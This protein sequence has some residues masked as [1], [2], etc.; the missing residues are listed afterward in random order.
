M[1]KLTDNKVL[2]SLVAINLFGHMAISGG[3]IT[4]SLYA[5][6][7][8]SNVSSVGLLIALYGILPMFFSLPIGRWVDRVG[9]FTPML[10]GITAVVCGLIVP[11]IF[12]EPVV[13]ILTAIL[14]GTGFMMVALSAQHSIGHLFNHEVTRRITAFGWLALGH[15]SSGVLGPMLV[16][17]LIDWTSFKVAFIFLIVCACI[18]LW[19]IKLNENPLKAIVIEKSPLK[20]HN[21]WSLVGTNQLKRVYVVGILVAIPWD[22]FVFLMPIL[23]HQQNL[24]ASAIG[25]ILS[26]LAMGTFSIRFITARWGHRFSEW[27]MLRSAVMVIVFVYLALPFVKLPFLFFLLSFTLGM[28]VGSGQPNMLSLLHSLAPPGRGAEAIGLRGTFAN[29]S[30]VAVPL[31]FGFTLSTIGILPIFWGVA[32]LVSLAF[33]LAHKE[34]KIRQFKM[35]NK[36][37]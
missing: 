6:K 18:S 34:V 28:A 12:S 32:A 17:I 10:L 35:N 31:I 21:V 25:S 22:L 13:L 14:S 30:G 3:R 8:G 33:P 2:L 11:V 19:L 1:A 29:A 36:Q 26:A 37:I 9:P 24:S 16:G 7:Q 15:S 23:G 20:I 5:L 4:S 27:Q